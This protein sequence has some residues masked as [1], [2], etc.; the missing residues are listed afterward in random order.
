M[1]AIPTAVKSKLLVEERWQWHNLRIEMIWQTPY[2]V[3]AYYTVNLIWDT[4]PSM[5][6]FS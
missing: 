2:S 3:L 5:T 1:F 6:V 4:S